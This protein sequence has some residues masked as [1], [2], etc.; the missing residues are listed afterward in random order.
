MMLL[1]MLFGVGVLLECALHVPGFLWRG[2]RILAGA[3]LMLTAFASG[4]LL[5]LH[6]NLW[7]FLI[8]LISLYRIFN[9]LRVVEGR[10]N[11]RYLHHAT[12]RTTI[13]LTVLQVLAA[14]LWMAWDGWSETGH[15]VWALIA[16]GQLAA[17]LIVLVSTARRMNHTAWPK[18]FPALPASDLPTLT[19]AIPARNETED[20]ETCL[21]SLI[22]N[23]Y[24]KLEILVLDDCSQ[25]R[26][27]PEIIRSFAHDGVRFLAGEEPKQ[28]WLPKN[29]AYAHLLR[30]SSGEYVLFCGVDARFAP[31]SLRQ[32]IAVMLHKKKDMLSLLPWRAAGAERRFAIVQA[33]R[34]MWELAPPRRLFGRPSVLST[35]WVA[36]KEALAR[37]GGFEAVV[38]AIVPEA[39]FARVLIKDD[40]YSFMRANQK[41]G[42]ESIKSAKEQHDTAVRMRYPQLHRRPENVLLLG[43]AYGFFMLLPFVLMSGG[44]F[45]SVG[46]AAHSMA[47][48]AAILFTA[49]YLRV[50]AATRTGSPWFGLV[51]LPVGLLYD[52]TLLHISM[53]KYEFS[54]V[55]WKGRNVC[56]PAMHVIPHLPKPD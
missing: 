13:T 53:W 55:D 11:E 46:I 52:L 27:T 7:S 47:A 49:A 48:V 6:F 50:V 36:K 20:L 28:T 15:M 22:A 17:A 45:V 34:Y 56:I 54:E 44:F 38:R 1:L 23:D 29:Q 18:K 42:I 40:A 33:M 39:H 26:R 10:M 35:C 30:E 16:A 25:N 51:A 2:R 12:L 14:L 5:I 43:Q 31:G 19:V 32:L 4:A 37:I 3:A 8:F 9:C 21:R 41:L 24:P